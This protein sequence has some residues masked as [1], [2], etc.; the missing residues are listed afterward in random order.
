MLMNRMISVPFCNSGWISM[1]MNDVNQP[2]VSQGKEGQPLVCPQILESS[3]LK[4]HE[5]ILKWKRWLGS[6][7]RWKGG[8]NVSNSLLI[9]IKSIITIIPTIAEWYSSSF[10]P[11][12]SPPKGSPN[13]GPS[14]NCVLQLELW[15]EASRTKPTHLKVVK[16]IRVRYGTSSII[17]IVLI[18]SY[19]EEHL[20]RQNQTTCVE[21]VRDGINF[22]IIIVK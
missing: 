12:S 1:M 14:Q 7:N 21:I 2:T 8:I 18:P 11:P 5:Y 3:S 13:T 16:I 10:K 22:I 17:I 20:L 4:L 15:T 6:N 9:I 19:Y